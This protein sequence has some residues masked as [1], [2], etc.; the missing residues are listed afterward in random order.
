MALSNKHPEYST[1]LEDWLLMR[2]CYRGERVIKDKGQ[3]Y[4]PATIGM[5]SDG[6]N[7]GQV[8]YM[9][10]EAYK[11]RALFHDYV[12]EAVQS[13]IG[14][15]HCKPPIIKLPAAMEPMRERATVEGDS[16][17]NLLRFINE[18]QLITGRVGIMLD[19]PS[20]PREGKAMPYFARYRAETIIN[21]DDGANEELTLPKLNLV[22]LDESA[23]ERSDDFTW[24]YKNKWRVLMLGALNP[25]EA[26]GMYSTGEFRDDKANLGNLTGETMIRPSIAGNEL[27]EIPFVFINSKDLVT[28]V[29]DPPLIGLANIALA[30]YRGEADYRQNLFMQGQDTL[31]VAG[32]ADETFRLGAGATILLPQGG[33]A[34]YIGVTAVG[35]P[36][37]RLALENDKMSASTKSGQMI[38]T[39]SKERES[40]DALKTRI[41]A[42]TATLNRIALTGAAGLE[43]LLKTAA[44][45][46]G[47]NPE[48]VSVR[49]N[50]DFADEKLISRSL[51]ELVTAKNM[52]APLSR[53]SLHNL[54][55]DKG[56]TYMEFEEELNK[57][58]EEEPIGMLN[59]VM[60]NPSNNP[61]DNVPDPEDNPD[62]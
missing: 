59:G 15:M 49:P 23:Y 1:F 5:Q 55:R 42:Q 25:N 57:I 26:T 39:R 22:V 30:I 38:D 16:L 11:Q 50:L 28:G 44:K 60:N 31:V 62:A 6:M 7:V 37:Q 41:G 58:E 52:G 35:L 18:E 34:K 53:E 20:N 2:D 27:D 61:P 4:L 21:W 3:I 10:Y 36:E 13:M 40:G 17:V 46:L 29:D 51:V 8:G 48:E 32:S 19:L 14:M 9:A 54:M 45:W 33:E 24:T 47:A 12:K 56:L 43:Q